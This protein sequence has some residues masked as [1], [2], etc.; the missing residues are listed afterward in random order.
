MNIKKLK[1]LL[2]DDS[3]VIHALIEKV[4][5]TAIK[6][7]EFEFYHAYDGLNGFKKYKKYRPDLTFLDISM[8]LMSGFGCLKKIIQIDKNAK[9]IMLTA[10][11]QNEVENK[12][13]SIGAIDF[14]AK[15]FKPM[16]IVEKFKKYI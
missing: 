4:L 1:I 8:P 16:L 5:L 2:I 15:P 9:V 14:I 11:D 7:K 13:K 6:E 12:I 10:L 3:E